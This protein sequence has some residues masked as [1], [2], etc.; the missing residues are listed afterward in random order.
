MNKNNIRPVDNGFPD[1]HEK[2]DKIL[3][4]R[5]VKEGKYFKSAEAQRVFDNIKFGDK[6]EKK[7][8]TSTKF[9]KEVL[10][11]ESI[12]LNHYINQRIWPRSIYT[13][14]KLVRLAMS[15]KLEF[16]KRYLSKK[17]HVPIS[18]IWLLIIMFGVVI[19]V[20][21]VIFLLPQLGVVI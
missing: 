15:A 12:N 2:I 7:P 17:R 14:D 20:I 16:L 3:H 13:T 19:V 9:D 1:P 18:M 21:I 6:V 5:D 11:Y 8:I 4:D 10:G